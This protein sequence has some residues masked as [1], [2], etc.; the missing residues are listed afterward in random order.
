MSL[1]FTCFRMILSFQDLWTHTDNGTA[2]RNMTFTLPEHGIAALLLK[3]A[4]DEPA[5]ISPPCA[6]WDSCSAENGT[7]TG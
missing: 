5:D 2:I 6:V 7:Q 4:G 3:D 1:S